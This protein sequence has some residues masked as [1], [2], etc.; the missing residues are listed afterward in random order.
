MKH[1][2]KQKGC[3]FE[4]DDN[5]VGCPICGHPM[6]YNSYTDNDVWNMGV[7]AG[8][9]YVYNGEASDPETSFDN[10]QVKIWLDAYAETIDQET[11]KSNSVAVEQDAPKGD[12]KSKAKVKRK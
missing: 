6:V 4:A 8:I 7:D 10:R 11:T 2:C 1:I 5:P 3:E 9:Q 12:T